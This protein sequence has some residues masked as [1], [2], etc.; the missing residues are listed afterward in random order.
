MAIEGDKRSINEQFGVR[1][2]L[3]EKRQRQLEYFEKNKKALQEAIGKRKTKGTIYQSVDD[4]LQRVEGSMQYNIEQAQNL[5]HESKTLEIIFNARKALKPNINIIQISTLQLQLLEILSKEKGHTISSL[6]RKLYPSWEEKAAYCALRQL[7]IR[8]RKKLQEDSVFVEEVKSIYGFIP[9]L[10]LVKQK[11]NGQLVRPASVQARKNEVIIYDES[12]IEIRLSKRQKELFD[13]LE[14]PIT[15]NE[16]MKVMNITKQSLHVLKTIL[17]KKLEGTSLVSKLDNITKVNDKD[18]NTLTKS[19]QE[20][21]DLLQ[22]KSMSVQDI[23]DKLGK[24]INN[25]YVLL[26]KIRR[27]LVDKPTLHTLEANLIHP[28]KSH[29]GYIRLGQ[30]DNARKVKPTDTIFSGLGSMDDIVNTVLPE[31]AGY[32]ELVVSTSRKQVGTLARNE[33]PDKKIYL[34]PTE[35][36]LF[37]LLDV[38]RSRLEVTQLLGISEGSLFVHLRN[39]RRKL[40]GTTEHYRANN[41]YTKNRRVNVENNKVTYTFDDGSAESYDILQFA[42]LNP[43]ECAVITLLYNI[44]EGILFYNTRD[45]LRREGYAIDFLKKIKKIGI[46]TH[47]VSSD[48]E[49]LYFQLTNDGRENVKKLI[50]DE[51][52]NTQELYSR[53]SLMKKLSPKELELLEFLELRPDARISDIRNHFGLPKESSIA[54]S[55]LY[56][57]KQKL[58]KDHPLLLQL[59]RRKTGGGKL[60]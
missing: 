40:K 6:A 17:R 29:K 50:I 36:R 28:Y 26:S 55:M 60:D 5:I 21:V 27:K 15:K 49:T 39:L 13:L 47:F 3:V 30:E 14:K 9:S 59:N 16:I 24:S 10:D 23:A 43:I 8:L 22:K 37:N 52:T 31:D 41:I 1:A 2:N 18:R 45:F 53:L 48:D 11:R 57:L 7:I 56:Q 38:K 42:D 58:P 35:L 20:I 12:N 51:N 4:F 32:V 34:T 25:I 19:E 44:R 54:S 33:N 46:Y